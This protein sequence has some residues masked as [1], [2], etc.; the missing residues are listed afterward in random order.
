GVGASGNGTKSY[1]VL[2]GAGMDSTVLDC[3]STSTCL[4]IGGGGVDYNWNYPTTNNV[5]SS[6]VKG[7]TSITIGDASPFLVGHIMM[8]DAAADHTLPIVNTGGYDIYTTTGPNQGNRWQAVMVTGVS[9]N[10][11]SFWPPLYDTYTANGTLVVVHEA[12]KNAAF[13]GL[14][15]FKIDANNTA[16]QTLSMDEQYGSWITNVHT[17]HATNHSISISDS[18]NCQLDHDFFDEVIHTGTNGFG[19]GT[20]HMSGCLVEDN[21]FY[22]NWPNFEINFGTAGNVFAYNF[23]KGQVAFDIDTNHGP[24]NNFNLFEGNIAAYLESDGYFGS[25]AYETMFRNWF[26]GNGWYCVNLKRFSRNF[27]LIGNILGTPGN[28]AAYDCVAFGQPNI[29]NQGYSGFAPPWPDQYQDQIRTS[30]GTLTIN[31]TDLSSSVP[32]FVPEDA[33]PT[34]TASH[35]IGLYSTGQVF[36]IVGYIS[37]T[38]VTAASWESVSTPITTSG[39]WDAPGVGGWQELDQD[40]QATTILKDNYY[41]LG[42]SIPASEF[43][44]AQ[45]LPASLYLGGKP[46]WFGSLTW[47]PFDPANP[48]PSDDSI[49]AGWRFDHPGQ[50]TPGVTG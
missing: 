4:T 11:I 33:D 15:D 35:R 20:E 3:R 32:F 36:D 34:L 9:G 26:Q 19:L 39:F 13:V 25:E 17:Y 40:V 7:S 27:S 10:T 29:G 22:D 6:A 21:I 28:N 23:S 49:P 18:L 38:E 1:F 31:G 8:L 37:P 16:Q 41:Y 47:P 44:G 45:A 2:R 43:I 24:H 30:N 50:D 48:G 42:A 14:E 5:V 12:T 46:S